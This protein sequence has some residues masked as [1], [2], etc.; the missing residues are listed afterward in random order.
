MAGNVRTG[1]ACVSP[2]PSPCPL[3]PTIQMTTGCANLHGGESWLANFARRVR[4]RAWRVVC[5]AFRAVSF[6][7]GITRDVRDV[8][9]FLTVPRGVRSL[10]ARDEIGLGLGKGGGG[11]GEKQGTGQGT[12]CVLRGEGRA[13]AK[14]ATRL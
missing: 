11:W 2:A 8:V 6:T 3:H 5:L 12:T 10:P 7:H 9:R 1:T 13:D 4:F 14:R